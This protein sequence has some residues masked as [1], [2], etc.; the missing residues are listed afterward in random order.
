M[1]KL[2]I[3]F[4]FFIALASCKKYATDNI[5]E[6]NVSLFINDLPFWAP[7]PIIPEDNPLTIKK[8]ELGKMLFQDKILSRN[9]DLSCSSCHNGNLAFAQNIAL[10][11]GDENAIGFRNSPSLINTV[12]NKNFFKDGG[13]KSLE[14]QVLV[15]LETHFEFNLS[16]SEAVER[17]KNNEFYNSAFFQVFGNEPDVFGL[18][19]A[20]AA[21]ERTLVDFSTKY[22]KVIFEKTAYFTKEELKGFNL[23]QANCVSCHDGINFTNQQYYN[24]GFTENISDLGRFRITR[25]SSDIGK[26]KTPNLRN[27]ATTF[28]YMHDGRINTLEE[29][30][31]HY[32][33]GGEVDSKSEL[34][35]MNFSAEQKNQLI[36][37]LK[38]LTSTKYV[39]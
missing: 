15:P 19:R 14:L 36:A 34:K 4:F 8:V 38:T 23:F 9:N 28:P 17:L 27:V 21:Y 24:T 18:T 33:N 6:E 35:P 29:V 16:T 26:F 22:D 30:I 37:F 12:Y 7:K 5:K 25:D 11:I 32:S 13:V 2:G 31:E 1:K 10:P 3:L 39:N 20:I